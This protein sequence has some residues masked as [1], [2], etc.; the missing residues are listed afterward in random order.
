MALTE[1]TL[2][3]GD[4]IKVDGDARAVEAAILSAARGSIMELAWM[5]DAQSGQR[6][7]INPEYVVMLREIEAGARPV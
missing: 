4:H 3:G 2:T 1:I 6:V 5:T 7:G